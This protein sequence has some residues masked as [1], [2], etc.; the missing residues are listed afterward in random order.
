VVDHL[1]VHSVLIEVDR[2]N[3]RAAAFLSL[4]L[5]KT[6]SLARGKEEGM[7]MGLKEIR[8]SRSKS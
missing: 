3:Q 5:L 1:H 8:V 6:F 7:M 2:R 4:V